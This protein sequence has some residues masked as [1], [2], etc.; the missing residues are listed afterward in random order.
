MRETRRNGMRSGMREKGSK[1]SSDGVANRPGVELKR[2]DVWRVFC[3]ASKIRTISLVLLLRLHHLLSFLL[4]FYPP[5]HLPAPWVH[6]FFAKESVGPPLQIQIRQKRSKTHGENEPAPQRYHRAR[7]GS[8]VTF[9]GLHCFRHKPR[10]TSGVQTEA[11]KPACRGK[12]P[13]L[14]RS[15]V[16]KQ[17]VLDIKQTNGRV[18]EW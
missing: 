9:P 4:I 8:W 11:T 18:T 2:V 1:S 6:F 14:K 15:D 12:D 5:P 3:P 13:N 17:L 7:C 16:E 10:G